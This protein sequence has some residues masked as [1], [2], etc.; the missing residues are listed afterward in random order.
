[1]AKNCPKRHRFES[2]AGKVSYKDLR[3]VKSNKMRYLSNVSC[4]TGNSV[5]QIF[6]IARDLSKKNNTVSVVR[7][8]YR[9]LKIFLLVAKCWLGPI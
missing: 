4:E 2:L 9:K 1:M 3:L 6:Q 7:K 8:F 5:H